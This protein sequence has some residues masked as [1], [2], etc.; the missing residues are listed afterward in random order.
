MVLWKILLLQQQS[1]EQRKPWLMQGLT[2]SMSVK[3]TTDYI[4]SNFKLWQEINPIAQLVHAA[5]IELTVAV[6]ALMHQSMMIQ[7]SLPKIF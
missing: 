6:N 5:G 1:V 2:E 7:S 3:K 4:A